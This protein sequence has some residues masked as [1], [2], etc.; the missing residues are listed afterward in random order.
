MTAPRAP[1]RRGVGNTSEVLEAKS[2]TP[3]LKL[4]EVKLGI[5]QALSSAQFILQEVT[6][7]K[8]RNVLSL[9]NEMVPQGMEREQQLVVAAHP[10]GVLGA[11]PNFQNV[12]HE[13]PSWRRCCLVR[14]FPQVP[15]VQIHLLENRG[16]FNPGVT[17][18]QE[19][20]KP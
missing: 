10:A 2:I 16:G 3:R 17:G 5:I 4:P 19:A 13:F 1:R 18:I 14:R 7:K 15:K 11:A 6:G 8:F 20:A 12:F 9:W